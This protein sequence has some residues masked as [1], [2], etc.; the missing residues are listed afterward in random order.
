MKTQKQIESTF[1]DVFSKGLGPDVLALL[2]EQY[3]FFDEIE[4]DEQVERH[5]MGI[6]LL[7]W[8]KILHVGPDGRVDNY[9]QLIDQL[10]IERN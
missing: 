10:L 1:R 5:N 2:L 7:K 3:Y 4:T 9:K 6:E 8:C